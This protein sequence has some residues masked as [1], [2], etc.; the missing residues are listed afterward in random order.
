M[1]SWL[2][3]LMAQ[4]WW[5]RPQA[6]RWPIMPMILP[7]PLP[8]V[9]WIWPLFSIAP[10]PCFCRA[11]GAAVLG[12]GFLTCARPTPAPWGFRKWRF[13]ALNAPQPIRCAPMATSPWMGFGASVAT[14][15]CR[16]YAP[17]FIGKT[18]ITPLRPPKSCNFGCVPC[19][20]DTP[21]RAGRAG[22][23]C[24]FGLVVEAGQREQIAHDRII[25]VAQPRQR[26]VAGDVKNPIHQA[27]V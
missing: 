5:V 16:A 25:A 17:R 19:S 26:L 4:I 11:I 27:I 14:S 15:P 9:V 23:P 12:I 22:A 8:T 7:R 3:R 24:G 18:W 10:N 1:R 2:G 6:R 21:I 13:A 20:P